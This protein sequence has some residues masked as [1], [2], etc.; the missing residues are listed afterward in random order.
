VATATA[1]SDLGFPGEPTVPTS[2]LLVLPFV[3]GTPVPTVTSFVVRND[4]ATVRRVLHPDQF[5][6]LFVELSFPTGSLATLNGNPLGAGDSVTITVQPSAGS[7]EFILS[8]SG[9]EFASGAE[10]TARLLIAY[11]N[12]A[13][14]VGRYPSQA[15]YAAA[16]SVWLEVTPGRWQRLAPAGQAGLDEVGARLGDAGAFAVAAPR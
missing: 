16:L 13:A 1:C 15:E 14:G 6:T 3:A 7:Y 10:P 9:L 8:P 4:Q 11:G 2:D 5:N 12:L